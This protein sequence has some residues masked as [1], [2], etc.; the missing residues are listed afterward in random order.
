MTLMWRCQLDS[1]ALESRAQCLSV[2]M[3]MPSQGANAVGGSGG[4]VLGSTYCGGI[5]R[6]RS[7][8][9][10]E[11]GGTAYQGEG[12]AG[13]KSQSREKY[14]L[15]GGCCGR[16]SRAGRYSWK[17]RREDLSKDCF[18]QPRKLECTLRA[19]G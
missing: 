18:F 17:G 6:V 9:Q 12:T 5:T 3:A 14:S 19:L 4:S 16:G 15:S 11:N 7:I 10:V 2:A 8:W 1:W 13:A